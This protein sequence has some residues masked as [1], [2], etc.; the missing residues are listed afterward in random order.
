M[1]DIAVVLLNWNGVKLLEQ[2]LPSITA[3]STKA[4]IYVI[5]NAS[6]DHSV[7]FIEEN[8]PQI[9]VIK[10]NKN[11]GFC[12]GYNLGLTQIQA[13]Y[14][15]L[16]NT[17]IE[18]TENWLTDPVDILS[19]DP[20]VGVCQPKIKS[21]REKDK[22]EYAGA[23]GGYI[24]YL[25]YPFCRGR[26]F[27]NIEEDHH[28]YD[29][30]SEIFWASG[31]CFFIKASLFHDSGGFDSHFFAH[32]EEIDLCWRI[33]NSGFKIIYCGSSTVYHVGGAT[34]VKDNPKKTYLNFRNSLLCLV[35]NLPP[36]K[37]IPKVVAR[38]ILDGAAGLYFLY[39][40]QP[41][42]TLAILKA[43]LAFYRKMW[44][45]TYSVKSY[46]TSP[47]YKKSIVVEHHLRGKKKTSELKSLEIPNYIPIS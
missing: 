27:E 12:G 20:S 1:K 15:V 41:L 36:K 13:K 17:D 31:A 10:L 21:W 33:K 4:S 25:G 19:S 6:T 11:H 8:Y 5:D 23:A 3:H 22:F 47:I 7:T 40:K 37:Y 35:K 26:I 46:T 28:Q 34:L 45:Y 9:T 43:H 2:F 29:D 44:K 38:L 14:Y 18:V 24:D 30:T 32:M 42:H 16:V 39:K